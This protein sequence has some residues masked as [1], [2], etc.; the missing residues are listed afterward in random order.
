MHHKRR[1]HKMRGG[2]LENFI[3]NA[4]SAISNFGST[5]STDSANVWDKTKKATISAYNSV[6]GSP[7]PSYS[8]TGGKRTRSRRTKRGG[9]SGYYPLNG[10]GADAAPFSG[11]TAQPKNWV[12]GKRKTRRRHK[13]KH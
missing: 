3:S 7:T 4:T 8:V 6:V 2:F 11:E 10:V 1:T 9:L 13:N 12:G 5:L